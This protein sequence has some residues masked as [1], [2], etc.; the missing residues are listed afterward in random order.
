MLR[1]LLVLVA[2]FGFHSIL[3]QQFLSRYYT[4][5]SLAD[6]G[7]KIVFA[8]DDGAHGSELW[9]SNGTAEGTTLL[10]DIQP[11]SGGSTPRNFTLLNDKLY[12]TA[13][14]LQYGDELW[15]TDGTAVGTTLVSDI[16]PGHNLGSEPR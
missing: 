6:L 11:G 1:R 16:R 3:A 14:T 15:S 10:R 12:F 2:L 8:A 4:I 5:S 7:G 9:I 13:T